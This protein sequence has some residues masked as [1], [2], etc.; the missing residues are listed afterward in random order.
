MNIKRVISD[1][2]RNVANQIKQHK[3]NERNKH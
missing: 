3:F 1:D 2:E